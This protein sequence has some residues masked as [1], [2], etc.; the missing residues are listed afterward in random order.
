MKNKFLILST[1]LFSFNVNAQIQLE[2]MEKSASKE[3]FVTEVPKT[4]N[5]FIFKAP[6]YNN[7]IKYSTSK[8]FKRTI[9]VDAVKGND[10]NNG[11]T[12]DEPIKTLDQ[13]ANMNIAFGDKILLKGGETYKGTIELSN[14]N[15]ELNSGKYIY[16][17][18]YDKGKAILDFKGYP[19]GVWIQNTSNVIV[20]DIKMTGNGGPDNPSF[21]NRAKDKN[22]KQR[23]G[24]RIQSDN[25]SK[26]SL[27]EDITFYNIDIK[28]VFLLNP[29][30]ESRA[31]H[32]WDMNDNAGWGWGIFGEVNKG[33]KGIQNVDIK[34]VNVENVSEMGIR[35]KGAGKIDGS[36]QSNVSNVRIE[37]CVVYQVGGPGMQFNKC[38]D[39]HMKYCRITESGNRNDNRKWGRGSGMWTWGLNN[40]LLEYN[41]FEGAQGIADCC[42][43]HIDFNCSNVVIQ[44]CLSRY[45]CGGFIEILGKNHNCSYRFNISVNDGWRNLKDPNQKFWGKVGCPGAIFTVNGHNN[46][47]KYVG[48][49]QTY[50]YNNT[51]INTISGNKPYQNS[52]VFNI[53]TSNEGLVVMNNI[54]WL[55]KK[56]NNGWSMH[57]WKDNAA[58]DAA[59][60]FKISDSQRPN[61]KADK[62]FKG[63][64]ASVVRNMNEKELEKMELIMKNNVY[65]LYNSQGT[66]RF[67]KVSKAL[68]EGYWDENALGD[69][70]RFH[71]E[72]GS[73]AYDFIPSNSKLINSG[74][75]IPKLKSD[76]TKNGI[77]CG[78]LKVSS[79]FFGNPIKGNIIGA[80][81]PNAKITDWNNIIK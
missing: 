34:Y 26:Y 35:F 11:I 74:M 58:Y 51:I 57:R 24:I 59:F 32:Q 72:K 80:V 22:I 4:P 21:M 41:I 42:G 15:E 63:S 12:I 71:N 53:A 64:F 28:D 61:A 78:G 47:K 43:A 79:D 60:D 65:K 7:Q 50:I 3:P 40:F 49:F 2:S 8:K 81:V 5:G 46:D 19:A 33:G 52:N 55:D 48:P 13:L 68:A 36:K 27:V 18:S 29:V 75:T 45:N 62:R 56:M 76:K 38:N 70:P 17:G 77:F 23:Y 54:F 37:N 69:N 39:S 1:F 6:I 31:C 14:L 66:D 9:Y 30:K 16:I 44:K 67:S 25:S 10:S 73:E 20:A